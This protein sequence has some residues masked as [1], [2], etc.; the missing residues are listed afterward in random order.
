MQRSSD[1]H[2]LK[3]EVIVAADAHQ[4]NVKRWMPSAS[5]IVKDASG[6]VSESRLWDLTNFRLLSDTYI[7]N[8]AD[9]IRGPGSSWVNLP[10]VL[11][12][13][14]WERYFTGR[15]KRGAGLGRTDPFLADSTMSVPLWKCIDLRPS[16]LFYLFLECIGYLLPTQGTRGAGAGGPPI[17]GPVDEDIFLL[18]N[19]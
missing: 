7:R 6:L 17:L 10:V 16:R 8:N 3:T 14:G 2:A 5:L 18:Y 1:L 13:N 19:I 15:L 11:L 4:L 12:R 9:A